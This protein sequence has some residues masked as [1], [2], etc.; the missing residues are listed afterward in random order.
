LEDTK[1]FKC[2]Q[3][4]RPFRYEKNLKRHLADYCKKVSRTQTVDVVGDHNSINNSVDNSTNTINYNI[5]INL[6]GCENTDEVEKDLPFLSECNRRSK[7][8][9]IPKLVERIY[10][11]TPENQN[12]R[13]KRA[14]YPPEAYV[15]LE[16]GWEVCPL[17]EA[18]YSMIR[19]G[20]D[21]L[22][23]YNKMFY[24]I[25]GMKYDDFQIHSDLPSWKSKDETLMAINSKKRGVYGPIK[26]SVAQKL[27]AV[28]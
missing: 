17:D 3:C 22:I 1:P 28:K 18:I 19:K 5:T 4:D 10:L 26:H 2:E 27:K 14:K 11:K 8:S 13:H 9:G 6:F 24:E 23:R 25:R 21:V 15:L 16:S 7:T 20:T 12:V